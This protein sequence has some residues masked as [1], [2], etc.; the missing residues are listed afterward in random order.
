MGTS[1]IEPTKWPRI[2]YYKA[3]TGHIHRGKGKRAITKIDINLNSRQVE[4]KLSSIYNQIYK[5]NNDKTMES[6]LRGGFW[7]EML[8]FDR[9]D[10][11]KR[12]KY[13]N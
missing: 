4:F 2:I 11:P 5:Y 10:A 1:I 12:A 6:Y 3:T 13:K 7:K 8:V 9:I